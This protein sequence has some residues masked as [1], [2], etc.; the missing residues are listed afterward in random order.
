[1]DLSFTQAAAGRQT[2]PR[3]AAPAAPAGL[4]RRTF[5][6]LADWQDRRRA[7]A[8]LRALSDR[9]LADIGLTRGEI[10][11]LLVAATEVQET[12]ARRAP[13]GPRAARGTALA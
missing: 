3:Q 11:N 8:E 13:A 6:R 10:D 5:A 12:T 4:L 2:L 1:M 7:A 9:D